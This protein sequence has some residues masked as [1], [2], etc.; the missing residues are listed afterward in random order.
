MASSLNA[1]CE[2]QEPT[3]YLIALRIHCSAQPLQQQAPC[4]TAPWFIP[5]SQQCWHTVQCWVP[6]AACSVLPLFSSPRQFDVIA[7][8]HEK[9]PEL[10][11]LMPKPVADGRAVKTVYALNQAI[12]HVLTCVFLWTLILFLAGWVSSWHHAQLP[13]NHTQFISAQAPSLLHPSSGAQAQHLCSSLTINRLVSEI[14]F[15]CL[16]AV[17]SS[18]RQCSMG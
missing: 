17:L 10:R 12:L 14:V 3:P 5:C 13:R 7:H 2:D 11:G 16:K 4:Q 8:V 9:I 1:E 18:S 15:S 6:T